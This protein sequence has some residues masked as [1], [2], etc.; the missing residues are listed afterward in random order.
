MSDWGIVSRQICRF[1]GKLVPP[2]D[3]QRN[4]EELKKLRKIKEIET[5][6]QSAWTVQ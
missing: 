1:S 5:F 2:L 6:P 4:K 3:S